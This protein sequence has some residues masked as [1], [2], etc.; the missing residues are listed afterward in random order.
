MKHTLALVLMVCGSFG[1]FAEDL[2]R[3]GVCLSCSYIGKDA[4]YNPLV[5]EKKIFI[6]INKNQNTFNK[7]SDKKIKASERANVFSTSELVTTSEYYK[8]IIP[9]D[10]LSGQ[11]LILNRI[12][13][14]LELSMR[15]N[16]Q[17]YTRNGETMALEMEKILEDFLK[18]R[19]I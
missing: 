19:E 7:S 16:Y 18:D 6:F 9:I 2:C 14:K 10:E 5:S 15:R 12:S 11:E 17:C 3:E 8:T 13:L 1:A 4:H